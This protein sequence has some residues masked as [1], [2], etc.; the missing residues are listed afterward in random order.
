MDSTGAK[1]ILSA[2]LRRASDRRRGYAPGVTRLSGFRTLELAVQDV[3]KLPATLT[4]DALQNTNYEFLYMAGFS[5]LGGG[6]VLG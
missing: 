3:T 2:A 5:T 1:A 6:D 4:L